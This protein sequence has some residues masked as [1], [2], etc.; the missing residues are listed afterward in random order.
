VITMS[1]LENNSC[2]TTDKIAIFIIDPTPSPQES[3]NKETKSKC[4]IYYIYKSNKSRAALR[5]VMT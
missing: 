1:K 3:R 5:L 4:L 2:Y